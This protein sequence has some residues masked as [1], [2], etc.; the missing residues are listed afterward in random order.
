MGLMCPTMAQVD[1]DYSLNDREPV[2]TAVISKDQ[3]P[4]IVQKAVNVQF[5]QAKPLTWSKF[6]FALKEYG[7]VYDID[8]ANL[9]L[10]RFEITMKTQNGHDF[11]AV[12]NANGEL[13]E[14]REM[15]RDIAVPAAVR[16]KLLNSKYKDWT[17]TGNKEIIRF[18]HDHNLKK[19]NVEQ[20]FRLN[21][22]KDG[23]KR[24][25]SFNWQGE[26]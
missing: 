17:V 26:N 15:S 19:S 23:M 8:A 2:V 25:V 18:Y 24:A 3:V 10:D 7:W 12:Y 11:W 4:E 5:D 16:D 13:I 22:E 9:N 21:L 1:H 20:H 6:P 14:T